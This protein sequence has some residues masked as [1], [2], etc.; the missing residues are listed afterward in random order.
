MT[1]DQEEL[2][3]DNIEHAKPEIARNPLG[4]SSFLNMLAESPEFRANLERLFAQLRPIAN[5]G[6]LHTSIKETLL[7]IAQ[8]SES[9]QELFES[10]RKLRDR[11]LPE[12]W[13]SIRTPTIHELEVILIDEG[14]PL[15]WIPGP[16]IVEAILEA[17]NTSARRRVIRQRWKQI[18]M[19][20]EAVLSGIT[21]PDLKEECS[22]ALDC[23]RAIRGG[24]VNPAQALAASLLDTVL[25]HLEIDMRRQFKKNEFRQK[26]IRFNLDD[27]TFLSA[28][29]FAQY[30]MLTL[31]SG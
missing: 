1:D 24:Y 22:F 4:S 11:I 23:I 12:N 15:M 30:G 13:Q 18:L 14:I 2:D 25:C 10:F 8:Q 21:Y 17:E 7:P 3:R 19:D 20:C 29:T 28:L 16:Q 5:L 27:Y 26:G 9:W 31:A 6:L